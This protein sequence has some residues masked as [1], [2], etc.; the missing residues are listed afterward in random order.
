M[1]RPDRPPHLIHEDIINAASANEW[2]KV[3]DLVTSL[4]DFQVPTEIQESVMRLA[5]R[6]NSLDGFNIL[7]QCKWP[8][9]SRDFFEACK[10][11]VDRMILLP[12]TLT[13]LNKHD[14]ETGVLLALRHGQSEN[15]RILSAQYDDPFPAAHLI[16]KEILDLE[17]SDNTETIKFAEAL[18]Y[19]LGQ[20][21]YTQEEFYNLLFPAVSAECT[22]ISDVI[23]KHA[24]A[25]YG[26]T[27]VEQMLFKIAQDCL[28]TN[29]PGELEKVL[30]YG[31]DAGQN[32]HMLYTLALSANNTTAEYILL[33]WYARTRSPL[34][35]PEKAFPFIENAFKT[36]QKLPAVIAAAHEGD[37]DR[38][39]EKHFLD[40]GKIDT[41]FL[42]EQRDP[43][44]NNLLEI[45]SAKGD[46]AIILARKYWGERLEERRNVFT[47]HV[48]RVYRDKNNIDLQTDEQED[49]SNIVRKRLK[50]VG[51][52]YKMRP[53]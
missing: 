10:N 45:L 47:T 33:K 17:T 46:L 1:K 27:D 5:I 39:L 41:A 9:S 13:G 16:G 21:K 28:R 30:R 20:K 14:V 40:G 15:I 7:R 29:M 3:Q 50:I 35:T 12:T 2:N 51:S 24:L 22:I 52:T 26:K 4:G 44:G 43:F 32:D 31:M 36:A 23:H 25:A 48:P 6:R 34:T 37:L 19:L 11:N 38:F 49:R 18:D 42:L 8:L 53:K